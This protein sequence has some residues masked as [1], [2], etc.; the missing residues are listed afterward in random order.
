L[1]GF[2]QSLIHADRWKFYLE[3]FKN[4]MLMV[5][6]ALAVGLAI[7]LVLAIFKVSR[8][9]LSPNPPRSVSGKILRCLIM[10]AG[11]F[12]DLYTTV[13]RGTPVVLQLLV[14]YYI[15][16]RT[17]PMG[18]AVYIAALAFGIN[19]G[20]YV[21]EIIRAGIQSVE[22]GQTEAGRSLGLKP[23]TTMRLI[24]LP[25]AVKNILPTFFNEFISLLKETSIAGYISIQDITFAGNIVRSRVWTMHPLVISAAIY[26]AL[27]LLLTQLQKWL[28]RRM[29]A[30]DRRL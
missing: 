3:G 29:G 17:A 23:L 6:I 16:F 25:Q 9:G 10:A 2:Y 27:V 19:S 12:A 5:G 7:G 20:A 28:E 15:V 8:Q 1:D 18:M 24:V 26:L 4:T 30:S 11:L 14:I 21:C 13:I 22:R